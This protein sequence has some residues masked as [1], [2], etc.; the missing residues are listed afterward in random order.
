MLVLRVDFGPLLFLQGDAMSKKEDIE[1]RT[2]QLL[3]DVLESKALKLWDVEYL[4]EGPDWYLRV[5][6]D[7][8]GGVTIDD[9]VEVSRELSDLL[10]KED[11]ITE[12]YTLEVSSPGLGRILK[13]E[14]D[15][16]NSVGRKIDIKLYKKEDDRKEYTGILKS[17]DRDTIILTTDGIDRSFDRKALAQIRLSFDDI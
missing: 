10:D 15:F 11:Y 2:E 9:C 17:F 14:R 1:N 12:A 3:I 6:I 4:K 7:K 13:R 8:P 5:Y 16:I